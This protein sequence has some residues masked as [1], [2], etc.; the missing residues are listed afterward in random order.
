MQ[1]N[2]AYPFTTSITF[3]APCIFRYKVDNQE[4]IE[5]YYTTN[6]LI[7][8]QSMNGIRMWVSNINA[9][10]IQVLANSRTHDLEVGKAGQV[11]VQDIKWVREPD[12]TYKIAVIDVD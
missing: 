9:I 11:V 1:D 10:K 2:R 8:V 4:P 5:D 6:D 7:T 3:R 12:G